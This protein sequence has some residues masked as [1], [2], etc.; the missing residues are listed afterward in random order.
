MSRGLD[1][2]AA[3]ADV[4]TPS[5][6]LLG[7]PG[8]AP[9]PL[10][11]ARL[12]SVAARLSEL[13][14]ASVRLSALDQLLLVELSSTPGMGQ[15]ELARRVMVDP[16]NLVAVLDSLSESDLIRREE[17]VDDRRRRIVSLTTAGRSA[18]TEVLAAGRRLER[19]LLSTTEDGDRTA[20]RQTLDLLRVALSALD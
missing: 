13:Q 17:D 7:A 15:R 12:G 4:T 16:R 18:V 5:P 8:T 6:S 14:V 2:D 19:D 3:R 11:L 9:L 20:V 10:V 1:S